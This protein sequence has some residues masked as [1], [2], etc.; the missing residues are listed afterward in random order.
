MNKTSDTSNAHQRHQRRHGRGQHPRAR[1]VDPGPAEKVP[2]PVEVVHDVDLP[3]HVRRGVAVVV[4]D[5]RPGDVGR[6]LEDGGLALLAV[7]L[8]GVAEAL[9]GLEVVVEAA[10]VA[11][12]VLPEAEAAGGDGAGGAAAG[13]LGAG[14]DADLEWEDL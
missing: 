4:D 2:A 11:V 9:E 3:A 13:E 7:E 1:R 6:D 14:Q 12:A 10:V 8:E 5:V